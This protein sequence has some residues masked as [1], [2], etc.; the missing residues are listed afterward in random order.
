MDII[1]VLIIGVAAGAV[2]QLI[3]HE[4]LGAGVAMGAGIAGAFGLAFVSQVI[5][6]GDTSLLA[7]SSVGAAAS[8]AFYYWLI[9][10]RSAV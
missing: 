6:F 5:G 9:R 1:F 7:L 3:T 4:K 10:R 8:V 2:G